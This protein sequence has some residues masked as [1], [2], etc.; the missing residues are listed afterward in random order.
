MTLLT[1]WGLPTASDP[2]AGWLTLNIS[3]VFAFRLKHVILPTGKRNYCLRLLHLTC[4][5]Y[6]LLLSGNAGH[7]ARSALTAPLTIR[8]ALGV[9]LTVIPSTEDLLEDTP[10]N[11]DLSSEDLLIYRILA[12]ARHREVP[13]HQ[14]VH[15]RKL[16]VVGVR[17]WDANRKRLPSRVE[18]VEDHSDNHGGRHRSCNGARQ[19]AKPQQPGACDLGCSRGKRPELRRTRQEAEELRH[20]VRGEAVDILNLVEPMMNHE[21]ACAEAQREDEELLQ[22]LQELRILV[23]GL[24]NWHLAP[25]RRNHR[26]L[27]CASSIELV[28]HLRSGLD[29]GHGGRGVFGRGPSRRTVGEEEARV[30]K[31]NSDEGCEHGRLSEFAT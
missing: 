17:L 12:S 7:T 15:C 14:N 6:C 26:G 9:V 1:E 21:R 29:R 8:V 4:H 28:V 13:E 11:V 30:G 2:R 23:I 20:D 5:M 31:R 25:T 10:V 24:G 22:F 18:Q 3:T 16:E 27:L 19:H